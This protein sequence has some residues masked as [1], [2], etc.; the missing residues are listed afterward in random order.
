M[1][2]LGLTWVFGFFAIEDARI[3]FQYLF[4][5]F[6]ALQGFLIFIFHNLREPAVR[7]AWMGLCCRGTKFSSVQYNKTCPLRSLFWTA[8]CLVRPLY[9]VHILCNSIDL[10]FIL[11]LFCK[12]TCLLRP[13]FVE[14]FSGRSKQ[15]LLYSKYL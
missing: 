12:A 3:V 1:S 6:N 2:T 15:V 13:I 8:T 9:E 5:I 11:P 10:M 14:N 7:R 4:C